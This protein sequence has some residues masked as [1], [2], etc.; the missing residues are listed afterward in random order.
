[1]YTHVHKKF[2]KI[3]FSEGLEDSESKRDLY[4]ASFQVKMA[5][6]K[7]ERCQVVPGRGSAVVSGRYPGSSLSPQA[8]SKSLSENNERERETA[9]TGNSKMPQARQTTPKMRA[10]VYGREEHCGDGSGQDDSPWPPYR[11]VSE[12]V[13]SVLP[14]LPGLLSCAYFLSLLPPH[15]FFL[16]LDLRL[17]SVPRRGI[18]VISLV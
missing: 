14:P 10:S 12:G 1:M 7:N 5:R 13:V 6:K 11:T 18:A 9:L 16:C 2:L 8:A 15:P 3:E 17:L 4:P